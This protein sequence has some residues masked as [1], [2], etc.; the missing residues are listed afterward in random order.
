LQAQNGN[1]NGSEKIGRWRIPDR[2]MIC[3]LFSGINIATVVSVAISA[4]T[5]E[6]DRAMTLKMTLQEAKER[7]LQLM[8]R[9]YH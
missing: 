3:Q 4:K 1:Q 5:L 7:A 2:P 9:G 6:E 8:H